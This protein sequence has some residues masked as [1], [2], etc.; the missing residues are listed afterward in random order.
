MKTDTVPVRTFRDTVIETARKVYPGVDQLSHAYRALFLKGQLVETRPGTPPRKAR[1]VKG[2]TRG[3]RK[4]AER[5][6][7]LAAWR[8]A[9]VTFLDPPASE[10]VDTLMEGDV[11]GPYSLLDE[12][13]YGR[14]A[15]ENNAAYT[16]IYDGTRYEVIGHSVYDHATDSVVAGPYKDRKTANRR[17]RQLNDV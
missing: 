15:E 1:P 14:T 5:A 3:E 6:R 8:E 11:A 16:A 12:K 13:F 10:E 2:P 17:A 4:R 7:V 9:Q